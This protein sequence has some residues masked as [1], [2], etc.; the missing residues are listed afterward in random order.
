M[1]DCCQLETAKNNAIQELEEAYNER[2]QDRYFDDVLH[3]LADS[4]VPVYNKDLLEIAANHHSI[5]TG[6]PELGPAFNGEPTP[7]NIIAAN[8]YEYIHQALNEKMWELRDEENSNDND[9]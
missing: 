1:E 2:G 3:E 6:T 8:I 9:E 4:A 5:A 7:I